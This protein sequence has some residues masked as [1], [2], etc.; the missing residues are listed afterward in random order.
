MEMSSRGLGSS[1]WLGRNVMTF[2]KGCLFAWG[3]TSQLELARGGRKVVGA[4]DRQ[5]GQKSRGRGRAETC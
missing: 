2:L 3:R 1:C 5:V 4:G